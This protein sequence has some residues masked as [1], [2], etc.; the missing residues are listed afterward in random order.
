MAWR[1]D[2]FEHINGFGE[3]MLHTYACIIFI[4]CVHIV[5]IGECLHCVHLLWCYNV[6]FG[7]KLILVYL[8]IIDGWN[9]MWWS[10]YLCSNIHNMKSLETNEWK[11][12]RQACSLHILMWNTHNQQTIFIDDVVFGSK[13]EVREWE[14][15]WELIEVLC[16]SY[17]THLKL[18]WSRFEAKNKQKWRWW[19]A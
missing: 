14:T 18:M 1:K 13:G 16:I 11:A 12:K 17:P 15:V 10:T 19:Y 2:E 8:I 5:Y 9:N 4:C 7:I 3:G 6:A